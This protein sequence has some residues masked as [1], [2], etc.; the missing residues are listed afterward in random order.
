MNDKLQQMVFRLNYSYLVLLR[1]AARQANGLAQSLLGLP[2][3]VIRAIREVEHEAL[4]R[5]AAV[6]VPLFRLREEHIGKAL[7]AAAVSGDAG[8]KASLI[9]QALGDGRD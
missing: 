6:G 1:E 4:V 8:V 9:I 3:P 7:T 5:M 2:D